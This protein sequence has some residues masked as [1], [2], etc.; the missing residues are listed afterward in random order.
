[1]MVMLG[2]SGKGWVGRAITF[3]NSNKTIGLNKLLKKIF[4]P[5]GE[6]QLCIYVFGFSYIY[7][8]MLTI[9]FLLFRELRQT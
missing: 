6:N 9:L 2:I 4:S 7:I 8:Y 3:E 1:M 5:G